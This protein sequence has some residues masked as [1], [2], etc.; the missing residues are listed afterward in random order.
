ME[1]NP[2]WSKTLKY[3]TKTWRVLP[4]QPT[5]GVAALLVRLVALSDQWRFQQRRFL[6]RSGRCPTMYGNL[7]KSNHGICVLCLT[8]FKQ[9]QRF[10]TI[11]LSFRTCE[12]T[13]TVAC[14]PIFGIRD[15]F[16]L[17]C[18]RIPEL[19]IQDVSIATSFR[20]STLLNSHPPTSAES[21]VGQILVMLRQVLAD[22]WSNKITRVL[23]PTKNESRIKSVSMSSVQCPTCRRRIP[24]PGSMRQWQQTVVPRLVSMILWLDLMISSH[25]PVLVINPTVSTSL[26]G[27]GEPY[28]ISSY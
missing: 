25:H 11:S 19:W 7:K 15:D 22:G 5:P 14:L 24:V 9:T 26:L 4:A 1:T 3:S 12:A 18:E 23:P 16:G 8:V 21:G 28:K 6:H 20:G 13:T 10:S 2:L 17:S 27:N